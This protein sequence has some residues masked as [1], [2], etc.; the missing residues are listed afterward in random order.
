MTKLHNLSSGFSYNISTDLSTEP[1]EGEVSHGVEHAGA[2]FVVE[3]DESSALLRNSF[4]RFCLV[5][6]YNKRILK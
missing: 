2:G 5:H 4:W 3:W 6:V 1:T